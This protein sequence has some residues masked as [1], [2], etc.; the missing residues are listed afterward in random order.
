MSLFREALNAFRATAPMAEARAS[1][2]QAG[3]LENPSDPSIFGGSMPASSGVSVTERTAQ[4]IPVVFA[5]D[6]VIKQDVAKTPIVLKQRLKDGSRQDDINDPLFSILYELPNPVTT[7]YEFKETMQGFL[8]LWGNAYA[9]I[10]R[11]G[12]GIIKA[13]WIL[14]PSRMTVDLDPL[15][16]LRY[17]YR[18]ATGGEK[19]WIYDPGEPAHPAPSAEQPDGIHGRSPVQVLRESM[20]IGD[21]AGP[22]SKPLLRS[23]RPPARRAVDVSQKLNDDSARRIRQDFE[24]LTVGE[25]NW[26]RVLVLDHDLKPVPLVMPNKRCAVP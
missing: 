25:H 3:T 23:G 9:E 22:L 26:H 21:R 13:L 18:L 1:V 11:D 15:N 20:G 4:S 7:A 6:K 24:T 2:I 5:C 14:D 8:N 17:R 19:T 16:R 10:E 12:R